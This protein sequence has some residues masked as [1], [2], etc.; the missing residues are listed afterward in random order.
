MNLNRQH[1]RIGFLILVGLL[2]L[3]EIPGNALPSPPL[4]S[5]SEPEIAQDIPVQLAGMG[6]FLSSIG[7]MQVAIMIFAIF[8]VMVVLMYLKRISALLALPIMAVLFG[9]VAGVSREEI[10]GTIIAEGSLRLHKTYTV[11]FFGGMLAIFVKEQKIAETVIKY[12]AEL[13]GDKPL[14]VGLALM[15]VSALLFTTLGGLGAII[16]VGTIILPIML[17]LGAPPYVAGGIF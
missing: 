11:A 4:S 16:M 3:G 12:T 17:S 15:A 6:S 7:E 14:V 13:A 10:V 2:L 5:I 9:L 1:Y 8:L